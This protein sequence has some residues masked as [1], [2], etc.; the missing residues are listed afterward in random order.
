[1]ATRTKIYTIREI[2][3]LIKGILE[4]NLP[5]RL[6]VSGEITDYR[7]NQSGHCY[8]SLKDEFSNLRCVMWRSKFSRLKFEMKNGLAVMANGYIDVYVPHGRYQ[9]I[10][11][12]LTEAGIGDLRLAFEQMAERLKGQGLFDDEHK[13]PLPKYPQRIGILTS[14]SGAAIGD[15]EN[16]IHCR[17]PC[18]KLFLY[19][20]PVG[21]DGA[22]AKIAEAIKDVNKRNN[23]L[24]LDIIILTRG[25]GSLEDLWAFNEEAT[26]R[27]IFDSK[28]PVISAIGHEIDTTIADLVA[29][30]R[31][32]TPTKAGVVA[33][34][35]INEVSEQLNYFQK[36]LSSKAKWKLQLCDKSLQTI[37][38]SSVFK[39][40]LLPIQNRQQQIDEFQMRLS[41]SFKSFVAAAK[42]KIYT[43]FETVAQISPHRLLTQK[44]V[45]L[46]NLKN[47]AD[48]ALRA[49]II[50]KQMKLTALNNKFVAMNPK[51]VLKRGYSITTIKKNGQIIKKTGD[52]EI[53]DNIITRLADENLIESKVTKK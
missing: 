18:A 10:A 23:R 3:S 44:F 36:S 33:V 25:G 9:F 40:P 50:D 4:N 1:M 53:G 13:K 6:T 2:N 47:K 32:S 20:I 26:A 37:L 21:G 39:N 29:D 14:E 42:A 45:Y 7:L 27:A 46:N 43:L 30:A 8:F 11:D 15:I 31:A 22:A 51:S 41:N 52:I 24:Q 34:P 12:G 38:A 35:D 5:G 28:I 49:I 48:S 17:W 19:P 16:S